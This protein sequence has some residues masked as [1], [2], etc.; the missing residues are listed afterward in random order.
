M[1]TMEERLRENRRRVRARRLRALFFL[2]LAVAFFGGAWHFVHRPQFAFGVLRIHGTDQITEDQ[3]LRMG[4]SQR[5]VNLFRL[6]RSAI[7]KGLRGDVRVEKAE[8]SYRLGVPP[9]LHIYVTERVPVLY[10]Q[11]GYGD[12]AKLDGQGL[13]LD[14]TDGIKDASVPRLTGLRVANVFTG[15]TVESDETKEVLRFLQKLSPEAKQHVAELCVDS[16][17]KLVLRMDYGFPVMLG[18]VNELAGKAELFMTVYDEMKG[19]NIQALYM[20][21]EYSKPYVRLKDSAV[22]QQRLEMAQR[23]RQEQKAQQ[24]KRER[25]RAEQAKEAAAQAAK[26]KG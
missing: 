17:H 10:V 24:E 13:V 5:P 15:D 21:L 1:K 3:I 9:E 6:S 14:V 2:V 4:G 16:N 18:P 19:K 20:D 7:L 11:A 8:A 22:E 23:E 12:Y 25:L 26:P